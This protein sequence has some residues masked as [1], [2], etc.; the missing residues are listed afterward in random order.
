MACLSAG[1][2]FT[3]T[4]FPILSSVLESYSRHIKVGNSEAWC[5]ANFI[6]LIANPFTAGEDAVVAWARAQDDAEL[7]DVIGLTDGR[8][9]VILRRLHSKQTYQ[10]ALREQEHYALAFATSQH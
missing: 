3:L 2:Q 10:D 8:D 9:Y 1:A 4:N 7:V 6:V 5:G